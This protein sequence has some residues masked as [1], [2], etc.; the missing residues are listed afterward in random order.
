MV[1]SLSARCPRSEVV[2]EEKASPVVVAL[3]LLDLVQEERSISFANS[4][5]KADV[6]EATIAGFNTG[7]SQVL[8]PPRKLVLGKARGIRAD[9]EGKRRIRRVVRPLGLAPVVPRAAAAPKVAR[10][11]E[12]LK[13]VGAQAKV[14]PAPPFLPPSAFRGHVG[15]L[16]VHC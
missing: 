5:S 11:L 14:H 3:S 2:L 12:V 9:V 8:Q 15:W 13:V 10:A 6:R 7:A 16:G 1:A 4:S